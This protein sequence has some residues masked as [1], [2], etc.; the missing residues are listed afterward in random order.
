MNSD[1][2]GLTELKTKVKDLQLNLREKANLTEISKLNQ[3]LGNLSILKEPY[4]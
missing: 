1:V 4:R 2:M 3:A